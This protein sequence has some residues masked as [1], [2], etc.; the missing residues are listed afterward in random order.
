M[1]DHSPNRF[2]YLL[3]TLVAFVTLVP[4]LEELGYGGMIFNIFLSTILLSAAYA[5][6]E[7]R[8]YFI[9][10]S[11]LA[12]PAFVL[13]W[14]NNFVGNP[15]LEFV[16]GVLTVLF[17]LLVAA[18]I[19]SHVL[20]AERVSREKI[21]GALS[22]YL[23]FG[24]VWSLLYMME[25]FLVPGSF[26]YAEGV[27]TDFELV[28]YSFVTLTTLGYGDIVPVSPSARA[29]VTLEALTGQ[30]YL[31]VLVARLVGLQITHSSRRP[32]AEDQEK[33]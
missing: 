28:Y 1:F 11:I 29:L 30:L 18:L 6:S 27:R 7:S 25:D 32:S 10:A 3:I 16:A 23:I 4:F 2:L 33:S 5:A 22:V 19:L 14:I 8:G 17:L 13:R 12:V 9:L 31:T 20:K 21:F 26:R 15:W 24:V